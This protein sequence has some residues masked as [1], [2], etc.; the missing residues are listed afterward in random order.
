[1]GQVRLGPGRERASLAPQY[2]L[3][4][5]AI[6]P[7]IQDGYECECVE[8]YAN[9]DDVRV[10]TCD[11]SDDHCMPA[12]ELID[13]LDNLGTPECNYLVSCECDCTALEKT[14]EFDHDADDN[15]IVT[16][17]VDMYQFPYL[18]DGSGP[19]WV[20]CGSVATAM[21]LYWWS[22]LGYTNLTG[23]FNVLALNDYSGYYGTE[24]N[25]WQGLVSTTARVPSFQGC[26]S[27]SSSEPSGRR[28]SPCCAAGGRA[29]AATGSRHAVAGH[30]LTRPSSSSSKCSL[31]RGSR[32]RSERLRAWSP[33]P[34]LWRRR[35]RSSPAPSRSKRSKNQ[36]RVLW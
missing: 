15:I 26:L 10:W 33:P 13:C 12:T 22:G 31:R 34:R 18:C 30:R 32:R 20:G 16:G 36:T 6:G 23:A 21:L 4:P 14:V 28:S 8:S 9:G 29:P 24:A 27:R 3:P 19:N 1:M 7:N 35:K 17:A 25:D 5:D 2:S 11:Q